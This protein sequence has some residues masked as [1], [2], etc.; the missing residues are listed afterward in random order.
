MKIDEWKDNRRKEVTKQ[1]QR[2]FLGSYAG[3]T[4]SVEEKCSV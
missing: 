4:G 1:N 3:E 2:V